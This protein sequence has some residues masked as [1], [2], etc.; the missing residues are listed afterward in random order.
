[1]T[2][3]HRIAQN[4]RVMDGRAYVRG[5]HITVNTIAHQMGVGHGVQDLIAE[6][7]G[8][9]RDDAAMCGCDQLML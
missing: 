6:Y 5:T 4:P 3:L 8:L 9:Q 1:M 7:P 2:D